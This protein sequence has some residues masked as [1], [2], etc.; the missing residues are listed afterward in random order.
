[1]SAAPSPCAVKRATGST[2][3]LQQLVAHLWRELGLLY[4][5]LKAGN[6]KEILGR[7]SFL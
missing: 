1:M 7:R 3:E 4:P 2:P 5:E 6:P